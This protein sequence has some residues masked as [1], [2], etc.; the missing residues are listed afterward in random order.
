MSDELNGFCDMTI[1]IIIIILSI[2]ILLNIFNSNE[3]NNQCYF[4]VI[5]ILIIVSKN[6]N[7]L[8]HC[9]KKNAINEKFNEYSNT[10]NS[11]TLN[12]NQINTPI[13]NP[14]NGSSNDNQIN[15]PINNSK[16][17]YNNQTI[18][19]KINENIVLKYYISLLNELKDNGLLSNEEIDNLNMK[20]NIGLT[21]IKNVIE[22]LEYLK[23]KKIRLKITSEINDEQYKP[24]GEGLSTWQNEYTIL[25]TDKWKLPMPTPPVCINNKPCNIC[26]DVNN[27]FVQLKNWNNSSQ[28]L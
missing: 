1:N 19:N 16:N 21:D 15:N 14:T 25:N 11:S 2:I 26:P 22:S 20:I 24:L 8:L 12:D 6:L 23:R 18:N 3:K 27:K 17:S 9:Q 7:I 13:I 28:V 4:I 10:L 5:F